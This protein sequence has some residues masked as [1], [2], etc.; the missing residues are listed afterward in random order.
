M[1]LVFQSRLEIILLVINKI[2]FESV[3]TIIFYWLIFVLTSIT[4]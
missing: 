3:K 1:H 2:D 4:N